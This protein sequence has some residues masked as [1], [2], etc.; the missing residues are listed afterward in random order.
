MSY[1]EKLTNEELVRL[2]NVVEAEKM[3]EKPTLVIDGQPMPLDHRVVYYLI[4]K[5]RRIKYWPAVDVASVRATQAELWEI[6]GECP[7][8]EEDLATVS[9]LVPRG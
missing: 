7:P 1:F 5:G 6:A 4:A 8:T 9:P 2:L 3:S